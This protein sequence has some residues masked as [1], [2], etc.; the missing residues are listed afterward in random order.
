MR[1][2]L[3][4]PDGIILTSGKQRTELGHLEGRSNKWDVSALYADSP[5]D[6]RARLEW[7]IEASPD[8]II[9]IKILSERAGNINR[10]VI[11]K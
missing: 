4:L 6:N 5:T 2:E 3:N 9:G 1:V 7:V 8:V 10:E 11:L